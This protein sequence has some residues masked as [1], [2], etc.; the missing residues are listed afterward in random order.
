LFRFFVLVLDSTNHVTV[1]ILVRVIELLG[2]LSIELL[3]DFGCLALG[4]FQAAALLVQLRLQV[5]DE[6]L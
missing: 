5:V 3:R 4:H 1:R 2:E 6:S